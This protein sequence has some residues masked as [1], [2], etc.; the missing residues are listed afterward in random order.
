MKNSYE[1]FTIPR[2][3]AQFLSEVVSTRTLFVTMGSYL[4]LAKKPKKSLLLNSVSLVFLS[5]SSK[6]NLI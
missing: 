4:E 1:A 2:R 3:D 6:F 5:S